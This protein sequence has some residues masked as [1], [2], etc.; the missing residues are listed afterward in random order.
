MLALPPALS[1]TVSLMSLP[2]CKQ[3]G[4]PESSQ[5]LWKSLR[6]T[7][8]LCCAP[9]F[10]GDYGDSNLGHHACVANVFTLRHLSR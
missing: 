3:T 6:F 9:G 10:Y 7:S 1:E 8:H 5:V 2:M 4:W